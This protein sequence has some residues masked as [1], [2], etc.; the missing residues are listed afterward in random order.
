M[1]KSRPVTR[2]GIIR[3]HGPMLNR[4]PGSR[5]PPAPVNTCQRGN[6]PDIADSVQAF[7]LRRFSVKI[8]KRIPRASRDMSARKLAEILDR[9]S[10]D[11]SE[12]SWDRLFCFHARCLRVPDRGGHRRSLASHTNQLIKEEADPTIVQSAP[13]RRTGKFIRD[14]VDTLAGRVSAKLEEG[15]FKGAVRLA[16]SEDSIAVPSSETLATL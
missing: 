16:S 11:G 1:R 14:P 3:V 6:I 15:D 8:L 9:V 2:L 10:S 4:C 12:S 13:N 5:K 7:K